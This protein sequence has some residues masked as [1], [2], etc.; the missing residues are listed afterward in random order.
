MPKS[1][2]IFLVGLY[3]LNK[4]PLC[5]MSEE[6]ISDY[7]RTHIHPHYRPYKPSMYSPIIAWLSLFMLYAI[8]CICL[9]TAK[10]CHI[11]AESSALAA[12]LHYCDYT[13]NTH[14][15][16]HTH[17]HTHTHA[18]KF[19]FNYVFVHTWLLSVHLCVYVCVCVS[20]FDRCHIN[21]SSS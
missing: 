19:V 17:M 9:L 2:S 10:T 8:C 16:K 7:V 18:F 1:K 3:Q 12:P 5:E 14:V 6:D 11:P 21:S 13:L 4:H 20:V 15:H